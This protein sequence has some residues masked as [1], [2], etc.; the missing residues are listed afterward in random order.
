MAALPSRADPL[1]QGRRRAGTPTRG[2]SAALAS[3]PPLDQMAGAKT[4]QAQ[5]AMRGGSTAGASPARAQ[6]APAAGT[7]VAQPPSLGGTL[8]SRRQRPAPSL[9]TLAVTKGATRRAGL[10][11]AGTAGV[12]AG[13]GLGR[14]DALG[15][16]TRDVSRA[17]S[18]ERNKAETGVALTH[19]Q[20]GSIMSRAKNAQARVA[21]TVTTCRTLP[22][23][24]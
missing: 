18:R 4:Q 6:R 17:V 16:A 9:D 21:N 1:S 14:V 15:N 11:G 2:P 19:A 3:P 20:K 24:T 8:T 5:Q 13:L 10:G 7:G 23:T 12:T 22:T